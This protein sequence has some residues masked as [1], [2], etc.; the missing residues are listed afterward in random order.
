[1]VTHPTCRDARVYCGQSWGEDVAEAAVGCGML[2][3]WESIGGCSREGG[4]LEGL[5][6]VVAVGFDGAVKGGGDEGESEVRVVG[7]FGG[8]DGRKVSEDL[9]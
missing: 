7:E 4:A 3:V 6:E 8:V 5:K 1:M 2:E 9:E